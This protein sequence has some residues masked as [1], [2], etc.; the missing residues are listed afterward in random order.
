MIETLFSFCIHFFLY[1][2]LKVPPVRKYESFK[3][4]QKFDLIQTTQKSQQLYLKFVNLS[5]SS[6]FQQDN[7]YLLQIISTHYH[8]S[9]KIYKRGSLLSIYNT[10]LFVCTQSQT[11]LLFLCLLIPQQ[12]RFNL[13]HPKIRTYFHHIIIFYE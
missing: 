10:H 8:P 2:I 11:F 1:N 13:D 12:K 6:K 5:G 3:T 4:S 7:S 9:P